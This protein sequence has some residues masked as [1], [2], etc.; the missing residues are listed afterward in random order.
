M[1]WSVVTI[2]SGLD[3]GA[4]VERG[5]NRLN[6]TFYNPK[7]Q[8]SWIIRHQKVTRSIQLFPGYL[9]VNIVDQW[10]VLRSLTNVTGVISDGA[11]P[12]GLDDDYI[13]IL[14]AREVGGIIE[15]PAK[16]PRFRSGQQVT[17]SD[18]RD[19]FYGVTGVFDGMKGD[20]RCAVLLHL[21]GKVTRKVMPLG[22]IEAA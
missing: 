20:E 8:T 7:I 18:L 13:H 21:L 2:I 17:I 12:L 14:K 1:S 5:L 9:F 3:A 19:P 15:L 16:P 22:A 11:G 4:I 10:R 6:Y